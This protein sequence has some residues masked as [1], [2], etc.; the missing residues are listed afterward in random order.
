MIQFFHRA[1]TCGMSLTTNDSLIQASLARAAA[2]HRAGRLDQAAAAYREVLGMQPGDATALLSLGTLLAQ[3]GDIV[4]ARPLLERAAAASP[5]RPEAW[6]ALGTVLARGGEYALAAQVFARMV[7]LRPDAAAAHVNLGNVLRRLG[8][9][10]EAAA[11]YR[12]GV[13]LEPRSPH[14]RFNLG[15]VLADSGDLAGAEEAYAA[16][17][18]IDPGYLA[19]KT[20]L[21]N[22]RLRQQFAGEAL[23]LFDEVAAADPMFPRAQYNRG[24]ALQAV[25]REGDAADAFRIAVERAPDDL[26]AHNNL[27]IALL[28]ND[29]PGEA[30]VACEAYL[31]RSPANRK[32][33]AYKAAALIELGRRDEAGTLLDFEFLLQRQRVPAPNGFDSI[34]AFNSALAV[35][36]QQHPTLAYEPADKST[37]GGSQTG[38]LLAGERGPAAVFGGIIADAVAAYMRRLREASPGHPYVERLPARWNLAT[39]AVVLR[40]QGHQGPHFHPDGYISGVYYVSLPPDIAAGDAGNG[41]AGWIEF[42]RTADSI[43]GKAEPIL[44]L[45]RPEEGLMLLFPSYMYHRTIPFVGEAPRISIAFDILPA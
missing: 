36:V 4:Q 37:R 14:A 23:R 12:R 24:V 33:L 15:N 22:L 20:N 2:H 28:R 40:S 42:G 43:G 16:A 32:S 25:G 1:Y 5:E 26:E 11:S 17:L 39:W 7:S 41:H 21:G 34:D 30:L 10:E 3:R 6:N 8:R 9:L 44:Q 27:C 31:E 18:A 35:H 45:V 13:V 29:R 38:E 19:A